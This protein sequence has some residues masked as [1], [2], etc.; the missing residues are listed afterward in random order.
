MSDIVLK[1]GAFSAAAPF[2]LGFRTKGPG[3]QVSGAKGV[4]TLGFYHVDGSFGG[5]GAVWRHLR[6]SR[7]SFDAADDYLISVHMPKHLRFWLFSV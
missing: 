2:I 3:T 4:G 1:M 6:E 5:D 7:K